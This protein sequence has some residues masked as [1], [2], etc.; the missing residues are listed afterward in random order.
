MPVMEIRVVRVPVDQPRMA[1]HMDVGLRRH[2]GWMSM[3]VMFVV[4]MH[5]LMFYRLMYMFM[6]MALGQMQPKADGHQ[7]AAR[8]ER[9][10]HMLSEQQDGG[11]GSDERR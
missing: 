11:T 10:R 4:Q 2:F 5:V 8:Y 6:L 1:M 9:H 7:D 3:L